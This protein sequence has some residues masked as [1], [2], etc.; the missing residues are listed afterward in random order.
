MH[1]RLLAIPALLVVTALAVGACGGSTT[2]LTDPSEILTK[3]VEAIQNAKTVHLEATVDGTVAMDI[4]GTGQAGDI[5]LTG[6]KLVA[7][8]D[9]EAG[10]VALNLAVPALLGMTADVI[11]LGEDTYTRISMIGD[12]YTKS[13]T[14]DSGIPV[15]PSDPDA[16]L[17][18]LKDWLAKP[19]V[20][21]KKLDDTS[22]GSKTCYQ[23]EIDLS[24]DELTTLI[25]DAGDVG[26]AAITLTVLVEKDGLKPAGL[27]LKVVATDVGELTLTLT[28][29]KWD[30]A[31]SISA[32]PADQV[33]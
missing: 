12:K 11:V 18:E 14:S 3:S 10:N 26:D 27:T 28:T 32:P 20:D 29:S 23:V 33:E 15:D 6:T 13:S 16:S 4:T 31:V 17:A 1:R 5:T 24:A 22:C 8:V 25:P 30:E 7:D 2:S 9:I 21:P 19:E